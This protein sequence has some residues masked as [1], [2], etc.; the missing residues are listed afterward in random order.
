M[1]RRL[2]GPYGTLS[3]LILD[4]RDF[5]RVRILH[6]VAVRDP[7]AREPGRSAAAQR[8][9]HRYSYTPSSYPI[10]SLYQVLHL[11]IRR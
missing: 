9:A 11:L 2:R 10:R 6:P 1:P 4:I 7:S 8:S 5:I 3:V